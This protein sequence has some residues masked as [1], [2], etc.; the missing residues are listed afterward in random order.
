MVKK[1]SKKL[2]EKLKKE[3]PKVVDQNPN[4]KS[5][6]VD[7]KNDRIIV[8]TIAGQVIMT[9]ENFKPTKVTKK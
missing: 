1:L 5:V 6:E 7:E 8:E 3:Y 4:N 9:R 2:W